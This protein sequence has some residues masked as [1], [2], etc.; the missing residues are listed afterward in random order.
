MSWTNARKKFSLWNLL[1]SSQW[2]WRWNP[3]WRDGVMTPTTPHTP[4]TTST[5]Q[6]S[7]IEQHLRARSRSPEARVTV[8]RLGAAGADLAGVHDLES[9][10]ALSRSRGKRVARRNQRAVLRVAPVDRTAALCALALLRPGL[11]H[12]AAI[13]NRRL[14]DREEAESAVLAIAWAVVRSPRSG[15]LVEPK[16]VIDTIWTEVRSSQGLRRRGEPE[17]VPLHDLDVLSDGDDGDEGTPNLLDEA[18]ARG[19]L[20]F[21]QAWIIHHTRIAD[22]PLTEVAASTGQ[23]YEAVRQERRRAEA[24]L[25]AF[26]LGYGS[27]DSA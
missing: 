2:S 19:V 17:V 11:H 16:A 1:S 3:V 10:L 4:S 9:F 5:S 13:V 12:M 23:S 14:R 21:R 20:T 25:R 7:R 27:S 26:A 18:L 8:E 22:R 6:L 24:L 15:R